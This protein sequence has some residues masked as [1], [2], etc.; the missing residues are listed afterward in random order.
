[1]VLTEKHRGV[2]A[3]SPPVEFVF[4][5]RKRRLSHVVASC[6]NVVDNWADHRGV[7]V[8][9]VGARLAVLVT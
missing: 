4:N 3:S 1:M 2:G 9:V 7:S 5:P 6:Q 8:V